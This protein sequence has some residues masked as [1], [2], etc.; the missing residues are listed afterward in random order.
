LKSHEFKFAAETLREAL[1]GLRVPRENHGA[2][3][4]LPLKPVLSRQQTEAKEQS[5][6]VSGVQ[7]SHGPRFL[8]AQALLSR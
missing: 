6:R 7:H 5:A 8:K 3:E 2:R 1:A 4:D